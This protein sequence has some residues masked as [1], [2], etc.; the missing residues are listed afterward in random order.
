[1]FKSPLFKY[2]ALGVYAICAADII[3]NRALAQ[4]EARADDIT[5]DAADRAVNT[6]DRVID[7]LEKRTGLPLDRQNRRP[8]LD[9]LIRTGRKGER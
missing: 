4:V 2:F 5:G 7:R 8:W 6:V 1:M 9:N 3:V